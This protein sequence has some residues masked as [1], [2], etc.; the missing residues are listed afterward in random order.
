MIL[1]DAPLDPDPIYAGTPLC[2]RCKRCAAE[3]SGGAISTTETESVTVAGH[4]VEWGKFDPIKCSIAYRGGTPEYNPFMRPDSDP[5]TYAGKYCGRPELDKAAGYPRVYEHNAALEGARG[6][7]RAC[8][9]HL[10]ERGVLT[11]KFVNRFRTRKPWRLDAQARR[12]LGATSVPSDG[13]E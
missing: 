3:C 2:D 6:C 7:V 8:M 10:E 13:S 1:T 9:V 11:N 12:G 4:K 5:E